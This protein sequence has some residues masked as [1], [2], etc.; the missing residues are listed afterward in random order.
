MIIR[1]IVAI[2][3]IIVLYLLQT[4]VFTSFALA[5]VVPDLLIIAVVAIAFSRGPN[6]GMLTGFV[7]GILIDLTYS[8]FIGLFALMYMFIGFLTG[9]ASK[10][11]DENDYTLPVILV[12]ISELL[13][14]LLYYVF[15]YFLSGKLNFGFYLYRFMIPRVI[16]TILVS[17]LLYRIFNLE[18]IYFKRFDRE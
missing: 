13:Y 10:I 12:S 7:C 14:N 16:Y 9:F 11:Y 17:I 6:K 1:G 8:S 3:Q 5:G 15:F 18:N 2:I 4:S